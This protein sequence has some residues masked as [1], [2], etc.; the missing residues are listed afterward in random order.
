MLVLTRKAKQQIKIGEGD[1]AVVLTVVNVK[2]KAVKLGIH[3]PRDIR[4]IRAE[5][6][7]RGRAA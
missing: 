2:G 5:L 6:D 1:N 3:A 7:E 4:V